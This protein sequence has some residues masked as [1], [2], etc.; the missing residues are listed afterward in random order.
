[1]V[2][3]RH[4][5]ELR[6]LGDLEEPEAPDKKEKG[7]EHEPLD[8]GHAEHQAAF[9]FSDSHTVLTA[10]RSTRLRFSLAR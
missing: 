8:R 3:L 2:V 5:F 1:M 6:V 9:V 7:E 10:G 4:L